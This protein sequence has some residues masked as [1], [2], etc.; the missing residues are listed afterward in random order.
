MLG[1]IIKN[2]ESFKLCQQ[3]ALKELIK[4]L[5]EC[6]Q[7][8]TPAIRNVTEEVICQVMPLTGYASFQAV[9]ANLKP[10]VQ[11]AIKPVLEKVKNKVGASMV[12]IAGP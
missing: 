8:K 11:N 12:P 9:L 5:V 6:L 1:W 3:D 4:P 2:K 10:A 7:D